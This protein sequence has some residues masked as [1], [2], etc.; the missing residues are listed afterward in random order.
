M[1][2]PSISVRNASVTMFGGNSAPNFDAMIL[3][4]ILP[5]S[6]FGV[7]RGLTMRNT[8]EFRASFIHQDVLVVG[9]AL[10]L[11]IPAILLVM[12]AASAPREDS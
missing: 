11:A 10:A 4:L 5:I 3:A 8:D 9:G 1:K 2:R 12:L 6:Y 7:L